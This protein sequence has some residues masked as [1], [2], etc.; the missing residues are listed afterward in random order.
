MWVFLN[1]DKKGRLFKWSKLISITYNSLID[2]FTLVGLN[3]LTRSLESENLS[4]LEWGY[5][6]PLIISNGHTTTDSI[7]DH[8]IAL[9]SESSDL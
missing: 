9:S 4:V 1:E 7:R 2:W 8:N 5:I 6:Y 3:N